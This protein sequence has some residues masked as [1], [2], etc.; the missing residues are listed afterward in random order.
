MDIEFHYWVTGIVAH[1]AGFTEDEARTI[2]YSSQYVDDNDISYEVIEEEGKKPYCNFISQTMN[3]L[4]PKEQLMRIYPI[5]HFVPGDPL[6]RPAR[7]RDGKMHV[8]VTTPNNKFVNA[9]MDEALKAPHDVLLYRIGIASHAYVDSWAHQ[10]FVGWRES[11]N[12]LSVDP[13]PF[14][15][16][17]DAL[18]HPDWNGHRWEDSRLVEGNINNNHRFLSAAKNL[19]H[20]YRNFLASQQRFGDNYRPE[21]EGLEGKLV[22]AVGDAASGAVNKGKEARIERYRKLASWLP[23]YSEKTWFDDAVLRK[24]RGLKD[25]HEGLISAITIFKDEHYWRTD[26]DKKTTDW[27]KFQK[28]VKQHERYSLEL[29]SPLYEQLGIVLSKV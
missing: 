11:F 8:L 25:S 2:A 1:E 17:M 9:Q 4:K 27:Y 15:C 7:R 23:E 16:H 22:T 18:H 29:L 14:I 24:T 13:I 21:W 26:K 10:N 19:F 12:T 20:I 6:Y 28:A 5:F 3:I